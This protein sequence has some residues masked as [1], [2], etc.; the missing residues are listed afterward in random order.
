ML[1][2]IILKKAVKYSKKYLFLDELIKPS[3]P[4]PWVQ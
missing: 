1:A 3:Y 4:E 2:K